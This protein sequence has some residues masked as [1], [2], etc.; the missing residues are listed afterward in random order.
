M[1]AFCPFHITGFFALKP[2]RA[3][4]SSVGC[5]IVIADG[6]T[7]EAVV[8]EGRVYIN[9]APSSAPT[10]RTVLDSLSEKQAD[11]KTELAGPISCGLGTSGAGAL[12]TA[13]SLNQLWKLNLSFN[14]LCETAQRAEI[15]NKTGV[16]DVIAQAVGGVVI[17]R[18]DSV[19]RILAPPLEISYLVFG[20]LST[21]EILAD[22]GALSAIEKF[23]S[24]ALKKLIRKPT[25]DEFMR[26]SRQFACDTEM[27]SQKVRDAV[28]AVEATGGCASMAMLGDTVY[29]TDPCD[30]LSEFGAVR[31]TAIC[32]CG[33]HLVL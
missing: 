28:E 26:L 33:A 19:D 24:A 3:G 4:I 9:R 23:G 13:L 8:G 31:K 18:Q 17:R 11:V 6:A 5:G 12:S 14:T 21:P 15:V 30:A 10:T 27:L 2:N 32:N 29:G 7:T 20:P 22:R 16:G 25:F 1:K